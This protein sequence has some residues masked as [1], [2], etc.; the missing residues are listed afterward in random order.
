MKNEIRYLPKET[1]YKDPNYEVYLPDC[2]FDIGKVNISKILYKQP[3]VCL[4]LSKLVHKTWPLKNKP[5]RQE[6][7]VHLIS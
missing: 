5:L 4:A 7:F 1:Y 3:V 2:D 6:M